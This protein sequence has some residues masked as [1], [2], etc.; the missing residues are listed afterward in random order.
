MA[1]SRIKYYCTHT[2]TLEEERS[3]VVVCLDVSICLLGCGRDLDLGLLMDARYLLN[4]YLIVE[5]I[6]GCT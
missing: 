4:V 5:N 2:H 6:C 1:H 3:I